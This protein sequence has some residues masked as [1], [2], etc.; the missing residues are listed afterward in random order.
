S[1]DVYRNGT[2]VGSPAGTTFTDTGL[3]AGTQYSYTVAAASSSGTAGSQSSAVTATT[4]APPQ[5]FTASNY[6]Q[7]VAGRAH[8]SGG[9]VY[10]NGSNQAMGLDNTYTTHTLEETGANYYVIADS[11]C[12]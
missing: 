6:Q 2:Q 1:Y 9:Y 10:A 11:G 8:M 3:A 7:T 12:P 5:C 4:S